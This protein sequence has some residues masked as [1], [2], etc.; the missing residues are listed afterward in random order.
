MMSARTVRMTALLLAVAAL[1]TWVSTGANRGWTK[2]SVPKK[3]VDEVTGI[4]GEVYEERFVPGVDFLGAAALVCAILFGAS[5]LF[6]K[7]QT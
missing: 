2:T 3:T 1:V 4:V 7:K 6:P 5:F